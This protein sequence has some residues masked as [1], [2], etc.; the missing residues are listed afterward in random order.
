M[1]GTE[2]IRNHRSSR[3][4][5]GLI[6][7]VAV[8]SMCGT[9]L[10]QGRD[11]SFLYEG[12]AAKFASQS[13]PPPVFIEGGTLIDGT[14]A[15]PVENPGL[16]IAD[17][18]IR[19]GRVASLPENTRH[20]DASGKWILPGL[21]DLH[22]HLTFYLPG[23]F[24]AET[25][26]T[27]SFRAERFLENYQTIGVTTVADVASRDDIGYAMKRAQ[28]LGLMKGSRL[29]VAG[30]G[31]T[32]TGGHPSEFQPFAESHYGIEADGPW[33]LRGKVREAVKKG[34][35]FIKVFPPLTLE[36]YQAVVDEA[37]EWKVRVTSHAGGIQDQ[38]G[39][40]TERSVEAGVDSIQHLYPYGD[41]PGR[42]IAGMAEKG[43][44]VIPTIG[45][46]LREV[47]GSAHLSYAWLESNLGHNEENVLR[48]F[49]AL[50]KAGIKFGVGTES[51]PYDMPNIADVYAQEL[52]GFIRGGMS[53]LRIIQSATLHS[54]EAF[55]LADKTGSIES[56]KWGDVILLGNDPTLNI[57]AL[58]DPEL[59]IQGG[60]IVHEQ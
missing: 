49:R 14:S 22:A 32:V 4:L 40:S 29:Y 2:S 57:R 21:F 26:V 24:H 50:Q 6:A 52:E 39:T 3:W 12:E 31:I 8:L 45:Y 44:Y 25:D 5:A 38:S 46:H 37:H 17:G 34:A 55:G 54:A 43:I 13:P 15:A 59:V 1:A 36:E 19:L 41:D 7:A 23:G 27:T 60:A 58:V 18:T 16:L 56:G 48:N 33:A 20:I 9:A 30:P 42:V 47:S 53:P 28:R 51:N 35:D 10:G 11:I